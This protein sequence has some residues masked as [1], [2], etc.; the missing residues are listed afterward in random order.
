MSAH[1]LQQIASHLYCLSPDSTTDR[2]IL[3]HHG[4]RRVATT[5]YPAITRLN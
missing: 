1:Q 3:L 4:A 5:L 2:P